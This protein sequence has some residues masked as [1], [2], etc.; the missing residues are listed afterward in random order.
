MGRRKK[1]RDGVYKRKGRDGYY[2]SWKDANGKRRI[3]KAIAADLKA[4]QDELAAEKRRVVETKILGFTPP[5][6]DTFAE[7]AEQ[8]LNH[9][10][11]R[12][13]EQ[14]YEREVSIVDLH[15]KPSFPGQVKAIRPSDV[16]KFITKR[17]GEVS[18]ATVRREVM[19]LK[20][21]LS[22]A[23]K[24]EI[25]PVSPAQQV[26]LPP[27]PPGRVRYLQPTE[28][29]VILE[30][31]PEWL[32]PII[33]LAVFTGMRRSEILSL[34]FLDIDL[35]RGM[36]LLPQTKNGEGK[37]VHLNANA[38]SVFSSLLWG[39]P[40]EKVFPG[41]TGDRVTVTFKRVCRKAKIEDFRF[42]DLRHTTGSWLAMSGKD[43]YT[44]AKVLG[45]KDLRMSARYS[46]LSATYLGDA[47]RN[48]DKV[49]GN[50]CYQ[51]A[52]GAS[53]CFHDASKQAVLP[54]A[55]DEAEAVSVVK[56]E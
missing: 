45:H 7:L 39:N 56:S 42:H 49:F 1:D 26:E 23:V 35:I 12:V 15:L 3:K 37:I 41:I 43:I 11:A 14:E 30:L 16:D 47:V 19:I 36:I 25:I 48:L 40:T 55:M 46:H 5:A 2:M 4:A 8:F 9:Q 6:E 21:M 10:K 17:S 18:P 24:W 29:R 44:I 31:S 28:L 27:V 33:G 53:P 20:S 51:N 13:T 34:R 54:P 22:K 32:R 38:M 50:E 52:S